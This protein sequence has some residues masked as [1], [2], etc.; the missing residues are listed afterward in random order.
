MGIIVKQ[1]H[2]NYFISYEFG[3]YIPPIEEDSLSKYNYMQ[4]KPDIP[5]NGYF[6]V[7]YWRGSIK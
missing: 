2:E 4:W 6:P 3:I 1:F 5:K 7:I